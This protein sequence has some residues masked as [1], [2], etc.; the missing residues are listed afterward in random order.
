MPLTASRRP[1]GRKS[2]RAHP[3]GRER[4]PWRAA[5]LKTSGFQRSVDPFFPAGLRRYWKA[6]YL[7]GL[8]EP[9]STRQS[10]GRTNARQRHAGDHPA[11][12]RRDRAVSYSEWPGGITS[13]DGPR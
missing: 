10:S 12:R 3:K 2:G 5:D 13:P 6:L 9:R 1:Y 7:D 11:L 4:P 8:C